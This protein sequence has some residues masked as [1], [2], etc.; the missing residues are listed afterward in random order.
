MQLPFRNPARIPAIVIAGLAAAIARS[1]AAT[2]GDRPTTA[3]SLLQQLSD[4]TEHAY[5]KAHHGIASVQLPRRWVERIR[6]QK[7]AD[8]LIAQKRFLDEWE[9]R[10]DPEVVKTIRAQQAR[11]WEQLQADQRVAQSQPAADEDP[12]R[13]Q[14]VIV[15][16]GLLL[17]DAGDVLLPEFID[18]SE[19]PR[20][21]PAQTPDGRGT[22]A[23][24][25]GSDQVTNLTVVRLA[26]KTGRAVEI[27]RGRP[28]EGS[29]ALVVSPAAGVRL[30]VWTVGHVEPGI[31]VLPDGSVSGFGSDDGHFLAVATAKP[32]ADQLVATGHVHRAPLGV[33]VR[34][35]HKNDPARTRIAALG[36]APALRVMEVTSNSAAQQGGLKP[37]DLILAVDGQPV[38]DAPTF[39]AV[40]AAR[41][42]KTSLTVVR[43]TETMQL[44]VEMKPAP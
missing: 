18:P 12:P 26:D 39:A 5:D 37:D 4:D 15:G 16:K 34:E 3:P 31:T 1:P 21:T 7:A 27:S 35:V 17:D 29:L 38:G 8:T 13:A 42:G 28:P 44:T 6:F 36:D 19:M 23:T 25:V 24:F 43:E 22:T 9:K 11:A 40:I 33:H 30:V 41:S 10:L 20:P 32:V 2:P 14:V